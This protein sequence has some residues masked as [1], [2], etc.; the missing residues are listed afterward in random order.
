VP[1][2]LQLPEHALVQQDILVLDVQL[3]MRLTIT[4]LEVVELVC[5]DVQFRRE[6]E[7]H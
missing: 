4:F 3:V 5:L 6:V 1:V 2:A 7:R